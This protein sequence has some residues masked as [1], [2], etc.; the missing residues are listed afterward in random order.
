MFIPGKFCCAFKIY[1]CPSGMIINGTITRLKSGNAFDLYNTRLNAT[2]LNNVLDFNLRLGDQNDRD[3]YLLAGIV[4]QPSS[5]IISLSLKPDSLLLNYDPWTVSC[6]KL[7]SLM[8]RL[9]VN[10]GCCNKF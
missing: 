5:G 2:A 9:L 8:V 3:K 7:K 10:T 4:R 1:S 6:L